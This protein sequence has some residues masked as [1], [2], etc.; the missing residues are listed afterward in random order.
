MAQQ[1]KSRTQRRMEKKQ[2]LLLV[3]LL[4]GISLVSFFLGIMVGR[5]SSS[6]VS[7]PPQVVTNPLPAIPVLPVPPA[8][9]PEPEPAAA[10][11]TKKDALT[12]YDALAKGEQTPL[13]SGINLPPEAKVPA[14]PTTTS[15]P[16]VVSTESAPQAP[17][18]PSA[19][20][21][22]VEALGG[23]M[24]QVA[25]FPQLPDANKV[26]DQLVKKGYEV[27]IQQA[28]LGSRGVW[29]R[30]MVGPY[31]S[32]EA[33]AAA[34]ARLLAEERLVGMIKKQ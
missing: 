7:A 24:V 4:F 33:A 14:V 17:A 6:S 8:P 31:P 26:R 22:K 18:V 25:S 5:N 34:V 27:V 19:P 11:E 28:D 30:V 23:Y 10:A 2:A 21:A 12:F 16:P 29:S 20:Q 1:V 13:G 3:V 9:E 15:P 32:K